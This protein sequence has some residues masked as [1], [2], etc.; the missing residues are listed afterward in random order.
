MKTYA[1]KLADLASQMPQDLC[2]TPSGVWNWPHSLTRQET[3]DLD[4]ST[5]LHVNSSP[6]SGRVLLATT[7]QNSPKSS[8]EDG[9]N[10]TQSPLNNAKTFGVEQMIQKRKF[11]NVVRNGMNIGQLLL[12]TFLEIRKMIRHER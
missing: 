5:I 10:E 2:M 9:A 4:L 6:H 7:Q 8:Y 3:L 1:L 11:Q 12:I